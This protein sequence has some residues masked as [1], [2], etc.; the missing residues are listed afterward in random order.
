MTA[1]TLTAD[2]VAAAI[3]AAPNHFADS[4]GRIHRIASRKQEVDACDASN[5]CTIE[6]IAERID[7]ATR[8]PLA[9]VVIVLCNTQRC[10][11]D[12]MRD[13]A[14]AVEARAAQMAEAA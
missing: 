3:L 4:F 9:R 1:T 12:Q 5:I 10:A 2:P 14:A 6:G 13:V 7:V 11:V 8:D